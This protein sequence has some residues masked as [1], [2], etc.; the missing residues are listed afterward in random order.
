MDKIYQQDRI[1]LGKKNR[2]TLA[3]HILL[4]R[5]RLLQSIKNC[6]NIALDSNVSVKDRSEAEPLKI[7]AS[8]A[9]TKFEVKGSFLA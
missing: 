7:E 9:I 2:E 4:L 3:T 1:E 5:E 6:Q 8:I